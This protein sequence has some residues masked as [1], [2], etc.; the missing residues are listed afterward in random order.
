MKESNV[1]PFRTQQLPE[2]EE[3]RAYKSI[4]A[5]CTVVQAKGEHQ[6]QY[7]ATHYACVLIGGPT[8]TWGVWSVRGTFVRFASSR[9]QIERAYPKLVW[10]RKM[11]TWQCT[12]TEDK[13]IEKRRNEIEELYGKKVK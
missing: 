2:L 5:L 12:D 3:L 4:Y 10:K 6:R 8:P 1:V 11:A 13:S 7:R 9:E